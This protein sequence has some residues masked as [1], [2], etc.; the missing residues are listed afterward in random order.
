MIP[1]SK[2]LPR[3][4]YGRELTEHSGLAALVLHIRQR[5]RRRILGAVLLV[6]SAVA[7]FLGLK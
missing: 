1:T 7:V 3:R 5:R 2:Q 6:V 4:D